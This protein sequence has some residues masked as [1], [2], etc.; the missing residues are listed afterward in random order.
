VDD[1]GQ[2]YMHIKAIEALRAAHGTLPVNL[3]FIVEGEEEVGGASIS[4]YVAGNAAKLKA[5]VALVSDTALYAEECRRSASDC[6]AGLYGGRSQ[7]AVARPA[8]GPVRRRRAQ[9]DLWVDRIACQGQGCEGH[10]RI[11]GCATKSPRRTGREGELD[12]LPFS[13]ES[14]S[15]KRLEPRTDRRAR[16]SVLERVWARPTMEVHGIAGGFTGAGAKTVIPA[17]ACAK[18]ELSPGA[19][20]DHREG[21]RGVEGFRGG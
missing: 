18:S 6:G 14:F 11:P 8:L 3:K 4:K 15:R 2:F 16:F 7:R 9:P 17:K 21:N 13:E 12:S 5:D 20:P 19:E 1:K 10:I